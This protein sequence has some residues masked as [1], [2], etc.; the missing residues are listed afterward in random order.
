[1]PT[2]TIVS[3]F[4]DPNAAFSAAVGPKLQRAAI[5]V[6]PRSSGRCWVEISAADGR[7]PW[8]LCSFGCELRFNHAC[9]QAM[10]VI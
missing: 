1:M 2:D 6:R 8:E 10:L 7:W 4:C 3:S 5:A 9:N